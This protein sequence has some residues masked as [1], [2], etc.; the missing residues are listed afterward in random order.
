M[1]TQFKIFHKEM[2]PYGMGEQGRCESDVKALI[3]APCPPCTLTLLCGKGK[4]GHAPDFSQWT[5]SAS[6][7]GRA[8]LSG[9]LLPYF[10]PKPS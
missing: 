5:F 7:P 9:F 2:S 4:G 10:M 6:T 1:S 8:L 3:H